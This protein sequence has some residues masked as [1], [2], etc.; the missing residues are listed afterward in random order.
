MT[1]PL[2]SFGRIIFADYPKERRYYGVVSTHD[3]FAREHRR[4]RN[5]SQHLN[6][7]IVCSLPCDDSS[8]ACRRGNELVVLL[9]NQQQMAHES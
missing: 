9:R 4:D 8:E 6:E 3:P 1:N 5:W 7:D 2:H